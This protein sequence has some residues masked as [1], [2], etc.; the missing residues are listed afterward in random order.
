MSPSK[1]LWAGTLIALL[2]SMPTPS[3]AEEGTIEE[4]V[5]TGSY[6]KKKSQL[7]TASPITNID[8]EAID[9]T[10]ILTSQELFRWLPSNTGS[11]NQ[12]DALTQGGTPGTANVNLR[13]LGLGL[14]STLVLINGRRQ[15]VSSATANRGDTFVDINALMPMIMVEN[16]EVLK[17]GAAALYGSDAVAGVVNYKTRNNF[18]GFEF[19]GNYQTTTRDDDHQDAEISAIFGAGNDRTSV[20]ASASYLKRDELRLL[21]RDFPTKTESSFGQPGSFLPLAPSASVPDAVPG[22]FNADPECG[23]ATG[24]RSV[25]SGDGSLCLFDFGPSFTLAPD[26]KR[27]QAYVAA[28]HSFSELATIFG[29]F[30]YAKNEIAGGYSP[31]FPIL[32]FPVVAADHPGNPYQ[33]PVVARFRALGDGLE[34]PG[35]G[36]VINTADHTTNR[37]VLGIE[38][39]F[40]A[41]SWGYNLAFTNSQ[42]DLVAT[43]NDQ[44]A[45]R[46]NLALQGFGGSDCNPIT[47]TAGQGDCL[48]YN[49]FGTALGAQPGDAGYNTPEVLEYINSNNLSSTKSKLRTWDFVVTGDLFDMWGG[50]AGLALGYQNR[51]ESREANLSDDANRGD[52]VFLLGDPDSSAD[53]TID[54]VFGELYLPF[55]DNDAG[56]FEAQLAVRYE[57]YN[58]GFDSTDPKI[59][60][61]YRT[62]NEVFAGRFTWGTSFR[63]PTLFQQFVT[64]TS[65]NATSDPLTGS[66][67]FLGETATPNPDLLPEEAETF[68]LGATV[69]PLDGLSLSLDYYNVQYE[70]R[71]S[72]ESG[73]QLIIDEATVLTAAGCGPT[74]LNDPDCAALTND[75]IVRDPLTGTPLR[76][77]VNRFNAAE[78]ETSGFDF[79]L[80]Y[81][82]DTSFGTFILMNDSTYV[83]KYDIRETATSEKIEGAGFRNEDSVLANSIPELRSNTML[84]FG[85]GGHQA[86]MILRYIDSYEDTA[87]TIDSWWVLDLQYNYSWGLFDDHEAT[88]TLG[89]LNV[90]DED[91]PFVTGDTNEF[92][93]DT[94]VH[95]PRGRMVYA[96]FIYRM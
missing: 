94:K 7:D 38:G 53:R 80:T 25:P 11:E 32:S 95:D 12:A 82:W 55:M 30:G 59:G 5:V 1:W 13:G 54:A 74:D 22:Q 86:N 18:E 58:T 21:D 84:G 4:I 92:G 34:G 52:L 20:V 62:A 56:L 35:D 60:L 47:G 65:L 51:K 6:I 8:Q 45:S 67:V 39:Q 49:P 81:S 73:Q 89:A 83:L 78:A 37:I 16:I 76:I 46:L 3:W 40:G 66:L 63:A 36:R 33:V 43:A 42:N 57:D 75:Q 68:T 17:D 48:Y 90:T 19:R 41:S 26:E 71:L 72:Q 31:S 96:R 28:E 15:T 93:Y 27:T 29:E 50:T 85:S 23:N 70:N 91:P 69:Q 2:L 87:E 14:G 61:L 79:N 10:G 88:V 44:S 9:Q 77:F 64:D 24:S